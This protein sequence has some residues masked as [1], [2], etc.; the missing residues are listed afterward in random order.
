MRLIWLSF[1]V[2][3]HY[4]R[5]KVKLTFTLG[6]GWTPG[7][8]PE[9]DGLL[10]TTAGSVATVYIPEDRVDL[11]ERFSPASFPVITWSKAK[12]IYALPMTEEGYLKIGYRRTK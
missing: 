5:L 7:L 2:G 3:L 1:P 8:V 6:G 10:E 4:M 12:G 11:R 9:T